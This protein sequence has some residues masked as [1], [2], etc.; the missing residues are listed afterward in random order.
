ML[1]GVYDNEPYAMMQSSTTHTCVHSQ[2]CY[3][4]Q[5]L[6]RRAL[7]D[8]RG[9]GFGLPLDP[10]R[11]EQ[12]SLRGSLYHSLTHPPLL[13]QTRSHPQHPLTTIRS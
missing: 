7:E 8:R 3:T 12:A 13:C 1:Y 4:G 6:Y 9:G 2:S 10:H 5:A 11:H